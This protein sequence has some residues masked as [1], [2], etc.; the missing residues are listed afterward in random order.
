MRAF[1]PDARLR[2][3]MEQGVTGVSRE[4]HRA[5]LAV[6]FRRCPR[7]QGCWAGMCRHAVATPAGP[8]SSSL[9]DVRA[10]G[11]LARV[12]DEGYP[13]ILPQAATKSAPPIAGVAGRSA[14][15]DPV[16]LRSSP[17]AVIKTETNIMFLNDQINELRF[18]LNECAFTKAERAAVEAELAALYA[19]RD[20]AEKAEADEFLEILRELEACR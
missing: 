13:P 8:R 10:Y 16:L 15:L 7:R 4:S 19:Q 6:S 3:Q 11:W 17:V 5:C 14:I 1:V 9:N 2:R 18:E 20:A 12:K